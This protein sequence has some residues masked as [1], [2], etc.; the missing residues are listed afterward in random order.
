MQR[1]YPNQHGFLYQAKAV[2]RCLAAG[3][4][5]CPQSPFG[6]GIGAIVDR[7]SKRRLVA[8]AHALVMAAIASV[9]V[10][11]AAGAATPLY[12]YL[13][14]FASS[15]GFA[16]EE[17]AVGPVAYGLLGSAAGLG[18]LFNHVP[19]G[20]RYAF[21]LRSIQWR[22]AGC[23]RGERR[24]EG[25]TTWSRDEQ[26]DPGRVGQ[27]PRRSVHLSR[28]VCAVS[29]GSV[30]TVPWPAG[31]HA[32]SHSSPP[33]PLVPV[34]CRRCHRLDYKWTDQQSRGSTMDH[35]SANGADSRRTDDIP[36]SQQEAFGALRRR[37]RVFSRIADARTSEELQ[38]VLNSLSPKDERTI[39]EIRYAH[40]D[41]FTGFVER[42]REYDEALAE[43][44]ELVGD[45]V[46]MELPSAF[47]TRTA[48]GRIASDVY[49]HT[50]TRE[51]IVRLVMRRRR[52][53]DVVADQT[54]EELMWMG[55]SIIYNVKCAMD[56]VNAA[57]L[58][59]HAT[60]LGEKFEKHLAAAEQ[61]LKDVR[62]SYEAYQA[63]A[64]SSLQTNR[65]HA[66]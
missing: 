66:E 45:R 16:R 9:F 44:V 4:R 14:V 1:P 26:I 43:V 23:T 31:Q 5:E 6:L 55:R 61:F 11:V 7:A 35:H 54:L 10:A 13:A 17:Q 22:P 58:P 63:A 21:P 24:P 27:R 39:E 2:H 3:L 28:A 29:P 46:R 20:P 18:A 49:L 52:G 25:R 59:T 34:A 47:D 42:L 57:V 30:V 62:G 60:D 51:A 64:H 33:S 56:E 37:I 36:I 50:Q 8:V 12:L 48:F 41:E 40:L 19:T 53:A 32:T 38:H 65:E 15:I